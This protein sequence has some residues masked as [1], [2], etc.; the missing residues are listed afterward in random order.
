MANMGDAPRSGEPTTCPCGKYEWSEVAQLV[1]AKRA[2]D[3]K[4]KQDT[5]TLINPNVPL[6]ASAWNL[7]NIKV[8]QDESEMSLPD[9]SSTS[10]TKLPRK[11]K[12]KKKI[13][14][15]TDCGVEPCETEEFK[16][17]KKPKSDINNDQDGIEESA[18]WLAI[19]G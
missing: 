9:H 6:A 4:G 8:A 12:K 16:M 5:G 7:K 10:P 17:M 18:D 2:P 3:Q 13:T 11:K 19:D 15:L 14:H 1:P